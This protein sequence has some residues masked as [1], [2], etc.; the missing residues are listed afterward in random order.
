[1]RALVLLIGILGGLG[2]T[3][4]YPFAGVLLW[5]WFTLQQPHREAFGLVRWAP[6]NVG[7][8]VVTL[9]AW[10]LSRERKTPATGF[11][12]WML[13][14][15]LVWMTFNSFFAYD[16]SWSWPYWDRTWKTLVLALLIAATASTRVRIHALLW[17]VVISL[18]YY[19]VKGGVFTIMTG[20][21]FHV[22]G[23]GGTMIG[24]NNQ[25][26]LVLLMTLPLAQYVRSQSAN[27]WIGHGVLAGMALT[28]VSVLGS[29]SRGAYIS[30]AALALFMLWRVKNRFLYLGIIAIMVVFALNFMPQHFF[31]RVDTIQHAQQD[32]SFQGRL[33]AWSVA[34]R[35]AIDRFPFGAGYYAPQIATLYH[36][37]LPDQTPHAAHSI[38]F[39]VLGEHGFI[40]LAIYLIILAAAF[41]RCSR[42]ISA[43]RN[44]PDKRWAHDLAVAIQASLF[45][46]CVGGAALSLAY[47]DLFIMEVALLLPLREIVLLDA[48][49][50]RPAWM[51]GRPAMPQQS[52]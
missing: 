26:A 28:F 46:F 16:P 43:T 29:Y 50:K 35:I 6:L 23:P 45:V 30:L 4:F 19:G 15:F 44:L 37:Y 5:S 27:K 17:I 8:A 10:F 47:Y 1:M 33:D 34:Y 42:I 9:G 31:H 39:Q 20:G 32:E 41:I 11:I 22:V 40:G 51:R 52:S 2:A 21:F 48:K 38:Y 3:L 49:Q 25:L 12:F 7:I 36:Q 14:V 24:D 18:F 13:I